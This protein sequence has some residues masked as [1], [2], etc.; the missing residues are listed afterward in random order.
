MSRLSTIYENVPMYR[1]GS[2]IQIP[3]PVIDSGV[4]EPSCDCKSEPF[5]W[6]IL[7]VVVAL[8]ISA[9]VLVFHGK[10]T[11]AVFC[12]VAAFFLMILW[13]HEGGICDCVLSH[14]NIPVL[15]ECAL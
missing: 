6:S 1:G 2:F 12:L 15:G 7:L 14:D 11:Y 3:T 8:A 13:S 10:L 5:L 9:F 4:D